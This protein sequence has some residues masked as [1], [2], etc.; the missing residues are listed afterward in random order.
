MYI[1]RDLL[2]TSFLILW[3]IYMAVGIIGYI[4]EF[5]QNNGIPKLSVNSI[6][7]ALNNILFAIVILGILVVIPTLVIYIILKYIIY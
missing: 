3:L 5:I 2:E 6:K 1:D 4:R 7:R